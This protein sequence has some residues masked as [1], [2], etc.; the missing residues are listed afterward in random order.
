LIE[1]VLLK[2][3]IWIEA[4][5][6]CQRDNLWKYVYAIAVFSLFVRVVDDQ[7]A[8]IT[9]K[10]PDRQGPPREIALATNSI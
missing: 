5:L 6:L 2:A 3:K 10:E 4:Y 7:E 9:D 8:V 1:V